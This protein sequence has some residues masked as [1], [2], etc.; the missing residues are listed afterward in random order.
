MVKPESR[1]LGKGLGALLGE[2]LEEPDAAA[3]PIRELDIGRIRPNPYQHVALLDAVAFLGFDV[4]H[5]AG[6]LTRDD[7]RQAGFDCTGQTH[8]T[9]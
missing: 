7:G 2:Y 8:F 9:A 1:R 3:N 5:L 4:K 6:D